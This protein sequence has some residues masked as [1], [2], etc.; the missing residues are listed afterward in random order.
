MHQLV[1]D[2]LNKKENESKARQLKEKND[3]LI[4]LGLYEKEYSANNRYSYMYTEREWDRELGTY[5][6]FRKVPVEVSDSEYEEIL[7][8]Q[9]QDTDSADR[10]FKKVPV[11]VSDSKYKEIPKYQKQDT[12]SADDSYTNTISTA[13]KV[14]AWI[15][16]IGG[17]ICGIVLGNVEVVKGVYYTYTDT[18]FSFAHAFTYWAISFISGMSFLGF[19]EIIKLLTDIKHKR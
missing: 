10:Y 12:D 1:Q 5:R 9:N 16:F 17:F 8:Y 6:Y 11:E 13:L 19:A 18:E 7:K 15:V 4:K 14:I 3:L 2:Y